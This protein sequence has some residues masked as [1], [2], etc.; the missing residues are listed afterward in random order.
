MPDWTEGVAQEVKRLFSGVTEA[1]LGGVDHQA[2]LLLPTRHQSQAFFGLTTARAENDEVIS[3][4]AD[5]SQPFRRPGL[6][7]VAQK[8]VDV[9]VSEG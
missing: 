5:L 6:P 9:Y 7:P 4:G 8:A 2:E 1:R 3:V